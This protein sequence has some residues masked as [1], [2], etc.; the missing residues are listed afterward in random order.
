MGNRDVKM[1]DKGLTAAQFFE[2]KAQAG[3][4]GTEAGG[5]FF[6]KAFLFVGPMEKGNLF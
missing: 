4:K 6:K 1:M 5:S 3:G 2:V